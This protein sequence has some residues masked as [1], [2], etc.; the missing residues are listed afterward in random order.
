MTHCFQCGSQTLEA[1]APVTCKCFWPENSE[2]FMDSMLVS[3]FLQSVFGYAPV[4]NYYEGF[5]KSC[6]LK[7]F[8]ARY[9]TITEPLFIRSSHEPFTFVKFGRKA[10]LE[11]CNQ[12]ICPLC[13]VQFDKTRFD[14]F[15]DLSDL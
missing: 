14:L 5:C 11:I 15:E 10:A 1:I 6:W 13:S 12:P 8:G 3:T 9:I 7:M 4:R 2:R